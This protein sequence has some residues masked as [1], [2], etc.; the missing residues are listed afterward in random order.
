MYTKDRHPLASLIIYQ[1]AFKNTAEGI[2]M[3][4]SLQMGR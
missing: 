1:D 3:E 4:L 2:P